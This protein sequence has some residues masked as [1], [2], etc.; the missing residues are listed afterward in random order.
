MEWT[1]AKPISQ[2]EEDFKHV[3]VARLRSHVAEAIVH[4]GLSSQEK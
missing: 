4:S 1:T 3:N 2:R